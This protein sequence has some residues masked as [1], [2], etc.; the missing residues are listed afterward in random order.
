MLD[1][2]AAESSPWPF[3]RAERLWLSL[4]RSAGNFWLKSRVVAGVADDQLLENH[5]LITVSIEY[6]QVRRL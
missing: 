2:R 3:C 4:S 1:L 6:G 5:V